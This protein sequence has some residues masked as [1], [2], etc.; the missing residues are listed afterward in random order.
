MGGRESD[1]NKVNE[2]EPKTKPI[3][4]S[5]VWDSIDDKFKY[6]AM[7]K[8]G[9]FCAF[10][11]KPVIEYGDTFWS[12]SPSYNNDTCLEKIE[13]ELISPVSWVDSL[14]SRPE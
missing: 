1:L 5:D 6:I 4:K 14:E 12:V 13:A 11:E 10:L 9:E 2:I 3:Y 8:D 7:D